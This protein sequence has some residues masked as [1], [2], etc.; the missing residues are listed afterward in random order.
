MDTPFKL[1]IE[2]ATP[3]I[4]S[5]VRTTL[6]ALLSY[7]IF[8]ETGLQG[9]EV[10]PLMPLAH[11][12]GIF[13]GSSLFVHPHSTYRKVDLIQSLDKRSDLSPDLF[14]PNGRGGRYVKIDEVR[15]KYKKNLVSYRAIVAP[16]VYFWGVG[17]PER[18]VQLIEEFIPSIGRRHN[19]GGGQITTVRWEEDED[20]SWVTEQGKP[21]RQL[22]MNIWE[23]LGQET[24]VFAANV[25]VRLPYWETEKIRA[26]LPESIFI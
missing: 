2:V 18:A 7:A 23:G 12:D 10:L 5:P 13:K 17:D 24:E 11:E 3:I 19:A 20:F 21:A 6:D 16:E 9:I 22:P 4:M 26:V 8:R 25:A 15:G 1:I 14:Q